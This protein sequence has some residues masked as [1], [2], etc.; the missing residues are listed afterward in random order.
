MEGNLFTSASCYRCYRTFPNSLISTLTMIL[1]TY[2]KRKLGISTV[3]SKGYTNQSAGIGSRDTVGMSRKCSEIFG[4]DR[5]ASRDIT[6]TRTFTYVVCKEGQS[7]PDWTEKC[8]AFCHLLHYFSFLLS[9]LHFLKR[10]RTL[11]LS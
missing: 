3:E 4:I 2:G 10:S 6:G 11:E 1:P 9:E 5:R 8:G 7:T